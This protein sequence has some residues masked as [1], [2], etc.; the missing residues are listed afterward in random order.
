MTDPF[1]ACDT[2]AAMADL[3][4]ITPERTAR[5]IV[6]AGVAARSRNSAWP[7]RKG[8]YAMPLLPSFTATHQWVRELRRWRPGVLTAVQ[9]RIPDDELVAVGHYGRQPDVMPAAQAVSVVRGLAD[10][11]GY[12]VFIPRR[13]HPAEVRRVRPVPQ[14][15]GWRYQP[16]AHGRRP[17]PCPYCLAPGTPGAA[18][19]RRAEP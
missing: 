4:H 11:R 6:R 8:V 2:R 10:P 17:C 1:S 12:E 15:I 18:K 7:E 16:D 14:G 19:V 3:V 9:V 5:R 13:L